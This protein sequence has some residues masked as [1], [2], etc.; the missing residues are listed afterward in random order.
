MLQDVVVGTSWCQ[1]CFCKVHIPEGVAG[2]T[3]DGAELVFMISTS[4]QNA[5]PCGSDLE[6][7]RAR[8]HS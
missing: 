5:C 1:A 4:P 3:R 2:T 8:L 7:H 6:W